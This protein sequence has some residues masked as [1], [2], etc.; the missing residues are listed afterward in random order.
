MKHPCQLVGTKEN[1]NPPISPF[2]KGGL[3]GDL[4]MKKIIILLLLITHCR[5]VQANE[6]SGSS[7]LEK[8]DA[9][10]TAEN[11]KIT[12]TMIIKGRRG[13]R[14]MQA[15]SWVQGRDKAFT[16]YLSPPREKDTK[17]LKLGDELWIYSPA[18]DRTIKIAGHML[19]RSM[20]GSDISYEDYMED[21]K[22]SNMYRAE[23]TGEENISG[24]D[25]Y[26]LELSAK[27][28]GLSYHSRKMW[29][30]KKRYLPLR[31][32]RFAKS[33]KLLK[34]FEIKEVFEVQA[35]WYPK[36]AV[37]KDVLASGE[38]TESIIDSIEFNVDIPDHV[39]S[40]ASLR[41]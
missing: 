25:C 11:R 13:T 32:D 41:K 7:I 6:I 26:V 15:R 33:G 1:E 38:G 18:T 10:Y 36:R 21:P 27:K 5:V 40:K 29:V 31:E 39:F 23:L 34:T 2:G 9:N 19:R 3:K 16:E 14:T 24:R 28:E 35:R 37:F 20:M 30:D 22:L 12:S 4:R 8:I 17:M